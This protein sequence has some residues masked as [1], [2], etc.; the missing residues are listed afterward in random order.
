MGLLLIGWGVKQTGGFGIVLDQSKQLEKPVATYNNSGSGIAFEQG[1]TVTLNLIK[2]LEGRVK[3]TEFQYFKDEEGSGWKNIFTPNIKFGDRIITPPDL[4]EIQIGLPKDFSPSDHKIQFRNEQVTSSLVE[5]KPAV[6]QL[7]TFKDKIWSYIV[8]LTVMLGFW[9]TMSLSIADITR[10]SRSQKAQVS[11]Q[12][13]GLPG[14]MMLYSFVGIFVT[15][16]AVVNFDDILVS[17]DA[18]WDPVSLLAKFDSPAVVIISQVFM[19]IATLST[20]IAANVIA[21]SN[22]FANLSPKNISFRTGGIITGVLGI[23]CFPWLIMDEISTILIFVSGLLG[24]VLG[25]MLSDYFAVRKKNFDLK[26]LFNPKGIYSYGS[27]FNPA[28]L[29]AL[30]VG[31]LFAVIGFFIESLEPLYKLSWFSGFTV[32]FVL[33]YFLMKNRVNVSTH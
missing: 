14:T 24:P 18:P 16:A 8:W 29:I 7:K 25:I 20:N 13:I 11:G 6:D 17:N 33:Y 30:I 26:E 4:D 3:A 9:A 2:D 10:Y 15:C 28:A 21:P 1:G 5:L 12:F 32:S 31:V 19:L 22:A 27:G 23:L